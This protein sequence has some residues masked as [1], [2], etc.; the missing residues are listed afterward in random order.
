M[1][2]WEEKME[3]QILHR[4]GYSLRQISHQT[5]LSIN[6]VVKY[7]KHEGKPTYKKRQ[8]QSLSKLSP[9]HAYLRHRLAVA[10]PL[11]IPATVLLREISDQGYQGGLS[12]LRS[13]LRSLKPQ[14][15]QG[16]EIRF[17]TSPGHQMQVDWIEFGESLSA[18]VATLGF[19]RVSFVK[20]VTNEKIETLIACHE[21]AFEY[22]GGVPMEVLYD[23]MKTVIIERDTYGPGRHRFHASLLDVAKH[24]GFRL[25]V[26]RPYRAQ[27]KGKVE[28]F[29][30]YL[31]E[32]FYNPLVSQLKSVG[33]KL[34]VETA[35]VEV[36]KWLRDVAHVRVH[37]TTKV[38]PSDRLKEERFALQPLPL[39]YGGDVKQARPLTCVKVDPYCSQPLQRSLSVYQQILEAL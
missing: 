24:Y 20:F 31:R 15:V 14:G 2:E 18:F 12:Q 34:D 29:N 36:L 32:S 19:S 26:C 22:F 7:L 17:E 27:T 9:Y 6:T 10:H 5:G 30:R 23:N 33:L 25:R 35:N 11:F 37:G 13:Y 38:R 21:E 16:E 39:P 3:V 1:I 8:H 4:Q 28:R